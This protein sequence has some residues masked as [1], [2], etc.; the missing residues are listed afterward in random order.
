MNKSSNVKEEQRERKG[1]ATNLLV[2]VGDSLRL[3]EPLE[4]SQ[5]LLVEPPG[6]FLEL[7]SR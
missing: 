2:I 5:V 7:S 1:K 3:L 6:L 4:P